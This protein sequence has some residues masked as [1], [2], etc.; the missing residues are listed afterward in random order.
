MLTKRNISIF[1]PSAVQ[2]TV[3]KMGYVLP[4]HTQLLHGKYKVGYGILPLQA[5][6]N[7]HCS[8]KNDL[9]LTNRSRSPGS[10]GKWTHVMRTKYVRAFY[11]PEHQPMPSIYVSHFEL[12]LPPQVK[13]PSHC[14]CGREK[15]E[16]EGQLLY[17]NLPIKARIQKKIS[18][19]P[20]ERI[21]LTQ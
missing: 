20:N 8:V 13:L 19:Y 4:Y 12:W 1:F 15:N 16:H 3:W 6:E 11:L 14:E 21:K 18:S 5:T 17:R 9:K 2:I 10:F 7:K